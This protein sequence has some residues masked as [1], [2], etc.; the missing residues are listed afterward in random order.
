[1]TV[2]E[3]IPEQIVT[4]DNPVVIGFI[5]ISLIVRL[6]IVLYDTIY[7]TRRNTWTF[8]RYIFC[9]LPSSIMYIM[10]F[11]TIYAYDAALP[12]FQINTVILVGHCI[13]FI[14]LV[15]A[16]VLCYS[17]THTKYFSAASFYGFAFQCEPASRMS[18]FAKLFTSEKYIMA[19][20]LSLQEKKRLEEQKKK[21]REDKENLLKAF[22][23]KDKG[24]TMSKGAS[25]QGFIKKVG[26]GCFGWLSIVNEERHVI[27]YQTMYECY[28]DAAYLGCCFFDINCCLFYIFALGARNVYYTS[29]HTDP[30]SVVNIY[31]ILVGC[32]AVIFVGIYLLLRQY[33]YYLYMWIRGHLLSHLYIVVL[34]WGLVVEI[35]YRKSTSL[36]QTSPMLM[37]AFL[38]MIYG[39]IFLAHIGNSSTTTKSE[40]YKKKEELRQAALKLKSTGGA[41]DIYDDI[42]YTAPRKRSVRGS[43]TYANVKHDS[44][45]IYANTK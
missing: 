10:R 29:I 7:A 18:S 40:T 22:D 5:S 14:L 9:D 39:G 17:D 37:A 12:P 3:Q 41:D 15:V 1:M 32:V 31:L 8:S 6:F 42:L 35:F 11:G 2:I 19:V 45:P 33:Q 38:T 21:K 27:M 20:K 16:Y 28:F 44:E 25:K 30:N 26:S 24:I 36:S 43:G 4:F 23:S 13:V 34:A